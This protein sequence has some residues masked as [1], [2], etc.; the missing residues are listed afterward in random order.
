MGKTPPNFGRDTPE[1]WAR[2]PRKTGKEFD[3]KTAREPA[4]I[5]AFR[6]VGKNAVY[7]IDIIDNIAGVGLCLTHGRAVNIL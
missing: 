1:K 6:H 2:H 4:Q 5:K 3:G 7:I